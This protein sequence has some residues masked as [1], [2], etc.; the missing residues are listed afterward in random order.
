MCICIIVTTQEH[1]F[2]ISVFR[3]KWNGKSFSRAF[4]HPTTFC[5]PSRHKYPS[6]IKQFLTPVLSTTKS[7]EMITTY[8]NPYLYFA[9][10][11]NNKS[12][13]EHSSGIEKNLYQSIPIRVPSTS[14]SPRAVSSL[15]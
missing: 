9:I 7:A 2:L 11:S 14:S 8:E 12:N 10:I 6:P 5:D 1:R 3:P 15:Q 4:M 13:I